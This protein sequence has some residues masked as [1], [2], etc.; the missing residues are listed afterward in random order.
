MPEPTPL[1]DDFMNG[2]LS[3]CLA[4]IDMG[5]QQAEDD[6]AAIQRKAHEVVQGVARDMD[7]RPHVPTP[8]VPKPWPDESVYDFIF[9]GAA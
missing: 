4:G 6:M 8:H 1:T 3:G 7:R 5:R 9:G 2:Y